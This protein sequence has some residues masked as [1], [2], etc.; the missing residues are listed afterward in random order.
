MEMASR[1]RWTNIEPDG[2][3]AEAAKQW[4]EWAPTIEPEYR[5]PEGVCSLRIVRNEE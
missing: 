4:A 2:G 1:I 3:E 5:A